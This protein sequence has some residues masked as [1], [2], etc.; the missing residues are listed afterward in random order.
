MA[1]ETNTTDK[2][3]QLAEDLANLKL[4][5]AKMLTDLLKDKH[6]IAPLATMVAAAPAASEAP[7]EREEKQKAVVDVVLLSVSNAK[8]PVIKALKSL[9]NVTLKEAQ[10]LTKSTPQSIK[11]GVPREAAEKL[12]KELTSAGA[13]VELR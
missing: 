4:K 11:E 12:Q 7:A 5:E 3:T 9:L 10:D 13:T 6:G 2:L 1:N 8:L